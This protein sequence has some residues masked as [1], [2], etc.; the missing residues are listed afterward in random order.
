MRIIQLPRILCRSPGVPPEPPVWEVKNKVESSHQRKYYSLFVTH[1][2]AHYYKI[3]KRYTI[4]WIVKEK[5]SISPT[6]HTNYF[7]SLFFLFFC[8][9]TLFSH[10]LLV[11]TRESRSS[12]ESSLCEKWFSA[13]EIHHNNF[14]FLVTTVFLWGSS[15][16]LLP[17]S[18]FQLPFV[19]LKVQLTSIGHYSLGHIH[20]R[21]R[22]STS[23]CCLFLHKKCHTMVF[24]RDT[25]KMHHLSTLLPQLRRTSFQALDGGSA[26][27]L[28][29]YIQCKI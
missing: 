3:Q 22:Q 15:V 14:L 11:G 1:L 4:K 24:K 23:C 18:L 8:L 10:A 29:L 16:L 2:F 5:G 7:H 19:Q 12:L 6:T 27:H 9:K 17:S 21:E 25:I 20:M 13:G 26:N 28:H